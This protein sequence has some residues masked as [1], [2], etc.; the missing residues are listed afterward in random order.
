MNDPRLEYQ[1]DTGDGT[2]T[3]RIQNMKVYYTTEPEKYEGLEKVYNYIQWLEI[4]WLEQQ[5]KIKNEK[6]ELE[7]LVNFQDSEIDT[8]ISQITKIKI[9]GE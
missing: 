1:K 7:K 8:L 4:F 6:S 2:I 3:A 9:K 5:I